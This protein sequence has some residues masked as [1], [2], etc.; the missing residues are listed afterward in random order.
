[1]SEL[2]TV[3]R[4]ELT[5]LLSERHSRRGVVI[6]SSISIAVLGVVM[7]SSAAAAWH[8]GHPSAVLFFF[9]LPGMLAATVAADGFAGERER[10]TLETLLATPLGDRSI[11]LGKAAAA[12]AFAIGVATL[13]LAA[14]VATISF[15]DKALFIPPPILIVAAL[16]AALGSALVIAGGAVIVSL[17]IPV[18]RAAQQVAAFS[19]LVLAGLTT[20][21][22]RALGLPVTWPAILRA[23]VALI[24]IGLCVLAAASLL[25]RRS[26]FFERA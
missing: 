9:F 23:D 1:V 4:K 10:H 15:S 12:V 20:V 24:G 5:E 2:F 14:A 18:A 21:L 3:L 11:L 17:Y 26:R 25:F 19:S 8:A 6:Q 16:G 22:W 13:A 7:P